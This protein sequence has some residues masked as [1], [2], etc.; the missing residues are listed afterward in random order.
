MTVKEGR[1]SLFKPSPAVCYYTRMQDL[2]TPLNEAQRQVVTTTHGPVLVL[3]GAG[4]GKTRALT[5]R[6]AYL[7]QQG[8]AAP[9]EI[10]AVTFTNKAAAEM[11]RRVAELVGQ[12]HLTPSSLGTFH[13]LGARMLREQ[14]AWH[15]RGMR[16]EILDEKDSERFVKEALAKA[17]VNSKDLPPKAVRHS[18][19]RFKNERL[20][21]SQTQA[22]AHS[23]REKNI[24]N[25]YHF[26]EQLLTRHEA[27]DFD[28]LLLRPIELLEREQAVRNT[29]QRRWRWLSVD[30]YQDTN[31]LQDQW[32][33]LL[34]APEKNICVV[35]DDYQAIYSW[36]GAQVDHILRFETLYPNCITIYLTQNYRSTPQILSAANEVIA[37]NVA[38]KHKTLWT[39]NQTGEHVVVTALPSE[40]MEARFIREQIQSHVVAGGSLK[41]CVVLYRTNAQSRVFE[42]EFLTHRIPYSIIGGFKFYDR[43]EIKDTLALLALWLNPNS[44][45]AFRR[46][47]EALLPGVGPKTMATWAQVAA[48]GGKSIMEVAR[49]A[50][51]GKRALYMVLAGIHDMHGKPFQRVSDALQALLAATQY[52]IKLKHLPDGEERQEN[53]AELLNVAS[54]YEDAVV[55]LE[56]VALLSDIDS[57]EETNDRVTCMTLHAAKG[58]E[59]PIVFLT[60][61]EEG[62]LP[63]SNSLHEASSLE[64]ERRLMYVGMTRAKQKLLLTHATSR[65]WRGESVRQAPSRFLQDLPIDVQ[66]DSWDSVALD[67]SQPPASPL[68][69]PFYQ[70]PTIVADEYS[71]ATLSPQTIITHPVFGQGVVI[72]QHGLSATCIFEGH[73][74]KTVQAHVLQ[75]T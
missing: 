7:I 34:L 65:F 36:R 8:I 21:P 44:L 28:D 42:E 73:G 33:S 6:I 50:T 47:A 56:D 52:Q 16:F 49:E 29:Y 18:I 31:A 37:K 64:E 61:C 3:A 5:Y 62:L 32:L 70:E 25:A 24:A 72:E 17:G 55:F 41:D 59:Y 60:G 15:G 48:E 58:L 51:Q 13:G 67:V 35:G 57:L 11:K 26:Y 1:H 2:L 53:I 14:A 27:F 23:P 69:D 20:S 19:S 22:Q 71:A 43:K 68:I 10:L 66:T 9:H 12:T 46:V 74:L 40:R 4:S 75:Q 63:H 54:T 39:S 38:Q 45:L 30:E